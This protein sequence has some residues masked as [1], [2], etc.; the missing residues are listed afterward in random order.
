MCDREGL[1]ASRLETL[2]G[3]LYWTGKRVINLG[4]GIGV[5][6]ELAQDYCCISHNAAHITNVELLDFNS[7]L[8]LS[9]ETTAVFTSLLHNAREYCVHGK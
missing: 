2:V 8:Q 3:R 6:W 5:V 9:D 4:S 1:H 7:N